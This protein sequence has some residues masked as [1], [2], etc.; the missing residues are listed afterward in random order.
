MGLEELIS[1]LRKNEQKQIEE[2][3]Q[4]VKNEAESLRQH[5]ADAIADITRNHA[6]QLNSACQKSMRSIFAD[7]SIQTREKKLSTYKSLEQA[8][9]DAALKELSGLRT[10][11]YEAVF[12]KLVAE[13][14]ARQWEKILVNPADLKLAAHFFSAD[15][16]ETNQSI[17]GGLVASTAE[18]K[19][20]VDNTFEKRLEKKW[21]HLLPAILVKIEKRYGESTIAQNIGRM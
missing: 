10:H 3:W 5:I 12:A 11:N 6:E 14:P 4:A 13:L 8:L 19:I 2:I 1:T 17:S 7:A 20:I 18:N 16:I 9:K 21:F 15:I